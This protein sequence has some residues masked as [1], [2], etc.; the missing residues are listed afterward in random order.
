MNRSRI[1]V[2]RAL[3]DPG[4]IRILKMLEVRELCLCEL[5]EV[6]RLSASTVSKHLS[7]L[8]DAG[9]VTDARDGKWVNFRLNAGSED[10]FLRS[11]LA[12][13]A[14]GFA[15]DAQVLKDRRALGGVDRRK[16]CGL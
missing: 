11:Q 12:A 13:V 2:F 9:L 5:R 14:G 8:R 10:R 15:E 7:V 16:I 1:R 6:L 3:G 4:R